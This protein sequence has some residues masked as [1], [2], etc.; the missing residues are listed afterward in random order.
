MI[1]L[2]VVPGGET[3]AVAFVLDYF[4][5]I[6]ASEQRLTEIDTEHVLYLGCF[7]PGHGRDH[8]L[9]MGLEVLALP[10]SPAHETPV[11]ELEF[12]ASAAGT[13]RVGSAVVRRLLADLLNS[14]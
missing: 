9:C 2:T 6:P 1:S 8:Q 14:T 10:L 12:V 3:A 5:R 4:A 7:H 11:R 13:S